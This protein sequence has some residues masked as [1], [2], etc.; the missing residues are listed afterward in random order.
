MGSKTKD[1]TDYILQEAFKLFLSK[2]YVNVTTGDL[3]EATGITRGSIYYRTKNRDC[4]TYYLSDLLYISLIISIFV[5]CLK[6]F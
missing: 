5:S 3:E 2:E 1:K 6:A 4:C